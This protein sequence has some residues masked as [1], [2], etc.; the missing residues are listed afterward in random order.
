MPR[1]YTYLGVD[2]TNTGARDVHIKNVLEF[3]MLGGA[4]LILGCSS[5]TCN[6]AVRG[7]YGA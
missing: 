2:F 1:V 6:E 4:K 3:V 5:K 7:G